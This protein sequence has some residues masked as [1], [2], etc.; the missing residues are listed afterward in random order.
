[1]FGSVHGTLVSSFGTM[2]V[3]NGRSG[4]SS[5]KWPITSEPMSGIPVTPKLVADQEVTRRLRHLRVK[6]RPHDSVEP[7]G[8]TVGGAS[9]REIQAQQALTLISWGSRPILTTLQSFC[10]CCRYVAQSTDIKR[11]RIS[12]RA[13]CS[14]R[15]DCVSRSASAGAVSRLGTRA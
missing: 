6:L 14:M 3:T 13:A 8:H 9:V 15:G 11:A 12:G 2:P 5:T 1:M 7:V 10:D 4:L